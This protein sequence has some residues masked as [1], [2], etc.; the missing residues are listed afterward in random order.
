MPFGIM[1]GSFLLARIAVPPVRMRMMGWLAILS[2]VPLI[3]SAW[4]PPL[5]SV[6]LPW[7]I[8][9]GY[10]KLSSASFRGSPSNC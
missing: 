7:A 5:W 1:V 10:Q 6:L 2:C 8:L 3:G 9:E 4:N